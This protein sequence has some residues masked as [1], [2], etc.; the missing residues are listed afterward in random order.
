MHGGKKLRAD[1]PG[2]KAGLGAAPGTLDRHH[3]RFLLTRPTHL[4]DK[5]GSKGELSHLVLC[6]LVLRV[7]PESEVP[8]KRFSIFPGTSSL[9]ATLVQK[10][11]AKFQ[12]SAANFPIAVGT[13]N[14]SLFK[15][16]KA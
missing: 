4:A 11:V 6:S 13:Q 15:L 1:H 7:G 5:S 9:G 3:R 14:L 8:G 16:W 2:S 12:C 10:S